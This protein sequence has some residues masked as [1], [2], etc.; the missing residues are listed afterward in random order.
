MDHDHVTFYSIK[1]PSFIENE[2]QR[3]WKKIEKKISMKVE[4]NE[5][6]LKYNN[7]AN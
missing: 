6:R 5:K 7:M 3:Q 4:S 1:M 2:R